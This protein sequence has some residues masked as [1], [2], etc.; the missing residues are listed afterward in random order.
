MTP[1]M[2]TLYVYAVIVLFSFSTKQ[3]NSYRHSK[4]D[5]GST[6]IFRK[7]HITTGAFRFARDMI[8][9]FLLF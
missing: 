7:L 2:F 5:N 4:I 1:K 3:F 6:I 8:A 9:N